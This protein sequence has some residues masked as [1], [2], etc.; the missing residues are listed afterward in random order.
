MLQLA[1]NNMMN[2]IPAIDATT[3]EIVE[4]NPEMFLSLSKSDQM[5]VINDLPVAMEALNK[6]MGSFNPFDR[7]NAATNA[8]IQE[9]FEDVR[10]KNQIKG[11]VAQPVSMIRPQPAVNI[12]KMQQSPDPNA[13]LFVGFEPSVSPWFAKPTVLITGAVLLLGSFDLFTRK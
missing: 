6:G 13:S 3:G 12:D 11:V 9:F 4:I 2:T 10:K 1:D 8:K 7:I 5:E